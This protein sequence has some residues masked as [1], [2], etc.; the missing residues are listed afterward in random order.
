MMQNLASQHALVCGHIAG[1][2]SLDAVSSRGLD[3]PKKGCRNE[4]RDFVLDGENVLE[5][6]IV[7]LRPNMCLSLAVD[8]LNRDPDA[9]RHLTHASLSDII[10]AKRSRDLLR[11]YGL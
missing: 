10:H 8:Q 5:L 6:S 7:P 2:L 1:G 4:R 9:I 11:L 3:A